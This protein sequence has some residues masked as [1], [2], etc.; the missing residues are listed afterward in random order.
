[1]A[2]KSEVKGQIEDQQKNNQQQLGSDDN[3]RF[4][5]LM[6]LSPAA[7]VMDVWGELNRRLR[8]LADK[9][10]VVHQ[11]A[12]EGMPVALALYRAN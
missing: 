6:A 4:K 3:T 1:E 7:A 8:D 9:H 11:T 5:Q 2:S 10:S 12:T